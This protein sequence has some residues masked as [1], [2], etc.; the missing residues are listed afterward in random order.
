MRNYAKTLHKIF[1]Q[2]VFWIFV[3]IASEDICWHCLREA[4]LTNLQN[5]MFYEEI[6]I[7]QCFFYLSFCPLKILYNSKFII[8]AMSLEM[9]AVLVTRFPEP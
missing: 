2:H 3:S 9:N 4:I 6:R 7:K 8:M 1:K 5:I